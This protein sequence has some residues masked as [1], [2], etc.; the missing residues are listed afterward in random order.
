MEKTVKSKERHNKK[1][2]RGKRLDKKGKKE[3]EILL[4][5]NEFSMA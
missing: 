3:R 5:Y 2:E 4:N 1:G